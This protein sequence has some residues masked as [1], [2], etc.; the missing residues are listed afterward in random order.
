MIHFVWKNFRTTPDMF[1]SKLGEMDIPARAIKLAE[2][3]KLRT[4]EGDLVLNWGVSPFEMTV[5]V[6]VL[7]NQQKLGKAS[8]LDRLT[9]YGLSTPK[10]KL[11]PHP[12]EAE[13]GDYPVLLRRNFGYGGSDIIKCD[14]EDEYMRNYRTMDFWT[15]YIDKKY[16]FRIHVFDGDVLQITRK[17]PETEGGENPIAWNHS[18][19]FRQVSYRNAFVEMALTNLGKRVSQI[20]NYDFFTVDVIADE[21]GKFY[22]LE[23]NTAS[24]ITAENRV[25]LYLD[26]I[27][28]L[29]RGTE[30]SQT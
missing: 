7:N 25:D 14:N 26:K 4:S 5:P 10:W 9:L 29:Y 23:I 21:Y 3:K 12:P 24:G 22:I 27:V 20:F 8:V 18:Y 11:C 1:V 15:K 2:G 28:S 30:Q 19:G 6:K 17:V 16:E 13:A